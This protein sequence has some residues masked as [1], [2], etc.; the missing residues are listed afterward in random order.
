[1]R[2][3]FAQGVVKAI[4][5]FERTLISAD[6]RF[7]KKFYQFDTNPFLLTDE[8]VDGYE[9]FNTE[10]GDCFHCHGGSLLTDNLFHNNKWTLRKGSSY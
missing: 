8:E 6:T 10:K 9:I 3:E 1:M 7:D 5:Q 2:L 4:A